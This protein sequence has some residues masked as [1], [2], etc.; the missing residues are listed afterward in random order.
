MNTEQTPAVDVFIGRDHGGWRLYVAR[1]SWCPPML[2]DRLDEQLEAFPVGEPDL[3]EL[4]RH[5]WDCDAPYE[6]REATMG[7]Q[8]TARGRS[9]TALLV[10]LEGLF[11]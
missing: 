2:R 8:I 9:A 4:E 5:M 7:V 1:G 11:E 10:W 3:E 6:K